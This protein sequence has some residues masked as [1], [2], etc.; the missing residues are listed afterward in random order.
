[1]QNSPEDAQGKASQSGKVRIGAIGRPINKENEV[2]AGQEW[3]KETQIWAAEGQV[4][5]LISLP[6]STLQL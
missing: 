1:M 2:I 6:S 4:V 3:A 5:G